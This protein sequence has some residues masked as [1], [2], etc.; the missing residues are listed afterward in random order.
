MG[1]LPTALPTALGLLPESEAAEQLDLFSAAAPNKREKQE[2][3]ER[4]LDVLAKGIAVYQRQV[5]HI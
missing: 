3:L 2:E 1:F 5:M 4:A